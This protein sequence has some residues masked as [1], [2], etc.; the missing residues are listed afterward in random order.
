METETKLAYLLGALKDGAVYKNDKEKIYRI[1]I[2]QKSKE[3]LE[4]V[5]KVF[6]EVFNRDLFLRK[7]PRKELWYLEMNNKKIFE[8][9]E[10]LI[11][12][13]VPDFILQGT[14]ELK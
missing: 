13:P 12:K 5:R 2:Y 7:D 8:Q 10:K 4:L 9:L 14:L 11:Q 3:W 6:F 1:R